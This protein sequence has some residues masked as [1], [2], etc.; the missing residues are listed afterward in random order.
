VWNPSIN[1][2]FHSAYHGTLPIMA[3]LQKKSIFSIRKI[4][5]DFSRFSM[6]KIIVTAFLA[7]V[8]IFTEQ[9]IAQNDSGLGTL[10]SQIRSVATTI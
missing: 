8:C 9:G 10:T 5:M 4:F 7:G 1:E 6:H 3:V 2:Y